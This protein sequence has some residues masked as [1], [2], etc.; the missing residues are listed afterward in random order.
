MKRYFLACALTSIASLLPLLSPAAM[1]QDGFSSAARPMIVTL[2][3][4]RNVAPPHRGSPLPQ[5]YGTFTDLKADRISFTMVGAD[6]AAT[7]ATTS[8]AVLLIPLK[9]VYGPKN[10]DIVLDPLTHVL[11]N[12]STV[13][14]STVQSPIFVA[15]IDYVQDGTD[16]GTTQYEDAFQRGNFWSS[17][18]TNTNYHILLGGPAI[19]PEQS[20]R[21]SSSEGK[22]IE[23]PL[24]KGRVGTMNINAFDDQLQK[25]MAKMKRV[26]PGV[27]PLFLTYD[28]YLTGTGGCCIGGYHSA[29]GPQPTGL[30]YAYATYV[31]PEGKYAQDVSVLSSVLGGWLDDP[32]VDNE[33]GCTPALLEVGY[34]LENAKNYGTYPYVLNGSTYNLQSLV[35]LGYFGAPQ[36]NSVN[37]WLS[38]QNDETHVCPGQ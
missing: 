31:D 15:G 35:F 27:L 6:P 1:A 7:N 36:N 37:S 21:V 32:F 26:K 34:P 3:N 18:S 10:G 33:T 4:H 17:V 28:V 29:D 23:N 13:V 20:I 38:F 16:L 25:I 30:T 12:G 2:P 9:M 14:Q 22:L 8:V 19:L 24:G 11:A 5:W